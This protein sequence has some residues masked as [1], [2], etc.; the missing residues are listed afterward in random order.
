LFQFSEGMIATKLTKHIDFVLNYRSIQTTGIKCFFL[1]TNISIALEWLLI[2]IRSLWKNICIFHHFEKSLHFSPLENLC[3]F[4]QF[5]KSFVFFTTLEKPL[6]FSP[7]QV[8]YYN[9]STLKN[10]HT[11]HYFEKSFAFFTTLKNY[12][13]FSPLWKIFAFFT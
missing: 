3:I 12:S 1:K 11:F 13:Y 8:T 4:H 5:K 6:H 2:T 9:K 10:L 7:E